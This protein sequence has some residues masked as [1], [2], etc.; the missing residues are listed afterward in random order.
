VW[1]G[2]T[3]QVLFSFF[4]F[5]LIPRQSYFLVPVSS[6]LLAPV[7]L[8]LYYKSPE[9]Q[10]KTKVFLQQVRDKVILIGREAGRLGASEINKALLY[11]RHGL[12]CIPCCPGSLY[13]DQTGLQFRDPPVSAS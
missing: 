8:A 12:L 5:H 1:I 7:L 4:S 9:E 11:L 10:A 2:G 3:P 6:K 13:K